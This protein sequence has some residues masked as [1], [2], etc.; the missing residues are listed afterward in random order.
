MSSVLKIEEIQS[1]AV[2]VRNSDNQAYR[3]LFEYFWDI[4]AQYA[5]AI[6]DNSDVAKDILQDLWLDYWKRRET[7]QTSNI[8]AY[9]YS[10]LRNSCYKYIRDN[11]LSALQLEIV[12]FIDLQEEV[13]I[14]EPNK[15]FL[16]IKQ[17]LSE[18]PPRCR[19]IFLLSRIN[20]L[21]N[22]EIAET[23][24]ITKKTVENQISTALKKIRQDLASTSYFLAMFF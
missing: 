11:K 17:S 13:Y 3:I 4:M 10:A 5:T 12:E 16:K 18:L 20:E 19:E 7:I 15:N 23:F 22:L 2:K 6:V 24:S 8:K 21:S 9:L 1:L 14:T